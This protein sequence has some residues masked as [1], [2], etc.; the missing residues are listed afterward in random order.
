MTQEY[1]ISAKDKKIGRLATEVAVLLMGKN[2]Y[3]MY[4]LCS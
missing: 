1:K 2:D 4:L 3:H